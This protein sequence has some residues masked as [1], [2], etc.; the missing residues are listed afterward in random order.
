MPTE[1][2][3]SNLIINKVESKEVYNYMVANNLVNED[4]MYLVQGD[5][6]IQIIVDSAL[7]T[8][9]ENP[10]QNKVVATAINNLNAKEMHKLETTK[11]ETVIFT[12]RLLNVQI[13]MR[14]KLMLILHMHQVMQKKIRMLLV[15]L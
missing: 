7:N 13:G 6:E 11:P 15:T 3:L 9:S 8:A 14:R 2:G 1:K 5:D 10:V 12:S 4:E